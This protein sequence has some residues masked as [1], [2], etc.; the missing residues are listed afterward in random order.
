VITAFTGF[1]MVISSPSRLKTSRRNRR[2]SMIS[3]DLFGNCGRDR[4]CASP[5]VS[6]IAAF[7]QSLRQAEGLLRSIADVL[8]I[9]IAIPDHTTASRR[10]RGMQRA[11]SDD[12]YRHAGLYPYPMIP[13]RGGQT[14]PVGHSRTKAAIQG[15]T[16]PKS[17]LR[18]TS[19]PIPER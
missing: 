16:F 13:D 19:Q 10:P 5:G 12:V 18:H 6:P 8:G 14:V 1:F 2:C 15:K 3:R 17:E 9:D 7:H 4:S 11:Q